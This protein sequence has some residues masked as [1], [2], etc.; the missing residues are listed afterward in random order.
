MSSVLLFPPEKA[1]CASLQLGGSKSISNRLLILREVLHEAFP[2]NNLSDSEDTRLLNKVLN[3]LK[4]EEN[5]NFNVNHAGTDLRFLT[6]FLATR[7]G[8][9]YILNGSER[10]KERPIAELVNALKQIGADIQCPE[11][12][13][14]PPL[15]IIGKNLQGGKIQVLANISSQFISALLLISPVLPQ[16]LELVLHGDTVSRP[17]I[18]MSIELLNAFGIKCDYQGNTIRVLP[19]QTHK[20][21]A[22]E[23]TVESDWSS[24]SYWFSVCAL[25]ENTQIHLK[26]FNRQSLQ[27]DSRLFEL[28][29]GLGVKAVFDNGALT[30][31]HAPVT[32]REF[33]G[34][35]TACPDIAPTLACTCLGLGIKARLTGLKTL[36]LKE[37]RR[38]DVL[39]T[40]L[41]KFGARVNTSDDHLELIPPQKKNTDS[42]RISAHHDHRMAMSFAPLSVVYPGLQIEDPDVVNKSYPRFWEDLQSLGFRLN[43]QS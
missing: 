11:K 29:A 43:L 21:H 15:H 4:N 36:Q 9:P 8:G 32:I 25:S 39:K 42:I 33:S 37:S 19:V 22:Q 14:H 26:H 23:Y 18:T 27:A 31:T 2:I 20:S 1:I 16:G 24:A 12:E 28:Y 6:A 41:E 30:L 38:I 35:F 3:Q 5:L 17:Y 40:E 13:N 10:L 34:D 7:P